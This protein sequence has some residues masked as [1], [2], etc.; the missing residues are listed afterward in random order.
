MSK[1]VCLL[2]T[3]DCVME[4][5]RGSCLSGLRLYETGAGLSERIRLI[6]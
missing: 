5:A 3:I 2:Y 6:T 1:K 4:K